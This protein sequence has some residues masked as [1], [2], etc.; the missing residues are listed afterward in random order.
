MNNPIMVKPSY[1]ISVWQKINYLYSKICKKQRSSSIINS[2][3][4]PTSKV[5][6][7][8]SIVSVFMDKYSFYGY[9]CE[10]IN[11]EIGS[12]CSIA[13]YLINSGAMH[14]IR[15][16]STSP[17]FY[18]GKDSVIKKFS[19]FQRDPDKKQSK[20]MMYEQVIERS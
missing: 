11:C 4:Y 8:S 20:D 14:P 6:S 9:D 2:T 13:N 5:E 19:D 3:I 17:V 16:L 15:W 12:Y 10:L 1:K 7:G 18:Y